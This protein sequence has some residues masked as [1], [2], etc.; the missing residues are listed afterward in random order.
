[1]SSNCTRSHHRLRDLAV[2]CAI[3]LVGSP[4]LAQEPSRA[5]SHVLFAAAGV[6]VA[7]HYMFRGVR[8]N[9]TGM[10]VWPFTDLTAT[11]LSRPGTLRR[12]EAGFCFW[13]SLNTGDT[14]ANSPAGRPWYESRLSGRLGFRFS[15]GVSVAARFTAY[16]SPN[17]MFSAVK[18]VGV[19]LAVD[20]R[21]ASGL[22]AVRPHAL[23]AFEVATAPGTGQ[24]DGG[25]KAGKY[26]E[27]GATP[28]HS[29]RYASIAF[30]I[31]VGL[32]LS[33]YYELGPRDHAFGFLGVGG[34]VMVPLGRP[35]KVGRW[36]VHGGLEFQT[37][38]ETTKVFNGGDRSAMVVSFGFGLKP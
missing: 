16:V 32:S 34:A 7:N 33:D 9:S 24:L 1:M 36:H 13:N 31:K 26:L 23:F 21:S 10:V 35:T 25:L 30:P 18:E 3:T 8:Q 38:G 14:G 11:V 15:R 2:A 6:D 37:L 28:G 29:F 20:D 22:A 5:G 19:E 17:E 27:L 4:A 12:I